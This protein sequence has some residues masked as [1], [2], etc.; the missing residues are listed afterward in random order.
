MSAFIRFVPVLLVV[1]G[2]FALLQLYSAIVYIIH[3]EYGF[4]ALYAVLAIAGL[5]IARG[6]WIQRRT[7]QAHKE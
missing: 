4:G 2:L 3:G 1:V 7:F 6:L 5:A